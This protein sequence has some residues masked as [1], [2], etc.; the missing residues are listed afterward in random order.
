MDPSVG[1]FVTADEVPGSAFDP[2]SLHKYAYAGNDPVNQLDPSGRSFGDVMI[3]V[4]IQG[5]VQAIAFGIVGYS[6]ARLRGLPH[7]VA[8]KQAKASGGIGFLLAI[9][10]VGLA[11]SLFL[12]GGFL[13]AAYNGELEAL[14][15]W[16][17]A[18][19]LIVALVLRGAVTPALRSVIG[20][21]RPPGPPPPTPVPPARV[22]RALENGVVFPEGVQG[23]SP[24][25]GD[26]TGLRGADPMTVLERVPA[27]W[28]P[29][30]ADTGTGVVFRN[31]ANPGYDW[32]RIMNGNPNAK[33]PHSR[34]PYLRVFRGGAYLD[35][36]GVPQPNAKTGPG[37]IPLKGNPA[38]P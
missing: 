33:Y 6:F 9:P 23:T 25:A 22:F 8:W 12:L 32:I 27:D 17:F 19:Y 38:L 7:E 18:T 11:L 30:P 20:R 3:S 14:D 28:V 16:E 15:Y 1:R 24:R 29:E 36:A 13:W 2:P 5:I 10:Y 31:P 4:A 37:H 34:G 21:V 26:F 35:D